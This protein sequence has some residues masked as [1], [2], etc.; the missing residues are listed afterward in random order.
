[1]KVL[2]TG[3]AGFIGSHIVEAL[4]ASGK[5]VSVID[6]LSTGTKSN[7][8]LGAKFIKADIRNANKMDQIFLNEK[9]AFVIHLAAQMNVRHSINDPNNDATINILG[10]INILQACAKAQVK[11]IVVASSGGAIYGDQQLYPCPE[12][13]APIPSSP[14]AISKLA[15]EHYTRYFANNGGATFVALR[16]SNVY[17]PRQ[18]PKG[19]AGVIS[20]FLDQLLRGEMPIIF[21]NGSH[22]RD[23][24]W[25]GDVVEAF[26]YAMNGPSGIYNIGTGVETST[27]DVYKTISKLMDIHTNVRHNKEIYGEVNRNS[28]DCRLAHKQLKWTPKVNLEDGL[29]R[30]IKL[31]VNRA[32]NVQLS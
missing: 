29:N 16:L 19:E 15:L 7:L 27:L 31:S 20:I 10:S 25:V 32:L 26:L 28:L 22:T 6:N 23:Y 11:R 12:S 3:G 4:L 5:S 24:V 8:R 30:L 2:V 18:N 9:P 14:Y 13:L 1:M 21:G 17:G